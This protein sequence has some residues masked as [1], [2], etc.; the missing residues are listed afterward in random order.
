MLRILH[1]SDLQMGRPFRPRA[2]EAFRQ[3]AF[4][5]DPNLIVISG[6]LTQRAKLHEFQA[7]WK[8]LQEFP[9]VPLVVT[10]GNHDVPLYRFWERLFVPYRTWD[11]TIPHGRDSVTVVQGATVVALNSAS[12]WRAIVGGRLSQGQLR[13]ARQSFNHGPKGGARILVTHHHLVCKSAGGGGRPLPHAPVIVRQIEEMEVDVV[14]SGH[15]HRTQFAISSDVVSGESAGVPLITAGTST[16][17]RG[18][19]AEKSANSFNVLDVLEDQ[20]TVTPYLLRN[21]EE[22]F[23]AS[24]PTSLMR[25]H[26]LDASLSSTMHIAS[27]EKS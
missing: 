25:R 22:V 14:L 21:N 24:Q 20:I 2:A 8:F 23:V 12:P 4:K 18:R 19:G 6:D 5:L 17:R 16:S 26:I 9:Q 15:L 10:P 3:L 11:Q 1:G 13:F 27:E 7:A